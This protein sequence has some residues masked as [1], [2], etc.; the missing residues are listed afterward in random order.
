MG[1]EKAMILKSKSATTRKSMGLKITSERLA[2]LNEKANNQ[3][4]VYFEDLK[5]NDGVGSGTRVIIRVPV[6][7]DYFEILK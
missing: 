1:R 6:D 5:D 3:G 4:G 2:I 7:A